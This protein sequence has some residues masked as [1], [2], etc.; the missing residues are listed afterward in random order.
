MPSTSK[1]Q[2]NLMEMVAHDPAA[3]KRLGISQSVGREFVAADQRASATKHREPDADQRGG[4]SDNDADD[5]R[6]PP[7]HHSTHD[8]PMKMPTPMHGTHDAPTRVPGGKK[9]Y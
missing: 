2:H 3:A 1:R 7:R 4:R 9:G 6:P 8:M 5:T